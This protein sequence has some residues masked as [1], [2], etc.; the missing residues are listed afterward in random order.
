MV[1]LLA[2]GTALHP[3]F[4]DITS[5]RWEYDYKTVSL[6]RDCLSFDQ[7]GYQID[8]A[9]AK[10]SYENNGL[11]ASVVSFLRKA[12]SGKKYNHEIND[13]EETYSII[14][15]IGITES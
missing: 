14:S 15:R 8:V 7:N 11:Q 10:H 4:V 3:I 6:A 1:L 9:P 2:L 12:L 5:S 13:S